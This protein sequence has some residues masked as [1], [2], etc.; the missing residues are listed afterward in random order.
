M[1]RETESLIRQ[2]L[3]E[4]KR[5]NLTQQSTR[6][7]TLTKAGRRLIERSGRIPNDQECMPVL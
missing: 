6:I 5:S 7:Y 1:E 4:Q 3:V 2:G